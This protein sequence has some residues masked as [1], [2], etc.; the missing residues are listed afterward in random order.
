MLLKEKEGC[1]L[2]PVLIVEDEKAIADLIE[3]TLARLGLTCVQVHDGDAAADLVERQRFD[4]ILLDV[5]LPG[6]DGFALMEYIAPTGT[7]VIFLTARADVHDRVRGLH[8]GAY[9]YIVKPFVPEELLARAEGVLRHS[10]RWGSRLRLWDVEIDPDGRSVW[11]AGVPVELTPRE[12]ELL[13]TLVRN[14][15]I[16][17]YRDVLLERVWGPDTEV[18]SRALDV[19]I[20]RLRAKLGW[21]QRIRT[22]PG[23][24]YRLEVAP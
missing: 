15:N 1:R 17:L 4:L 20:H 6:V 21:G 3:I 5:M 16:A 10:G 13:L 2:Y 14:K 12:F 7:P 18:G 23:I 11:K 24:G 19:N 9:D 22:V 8:L